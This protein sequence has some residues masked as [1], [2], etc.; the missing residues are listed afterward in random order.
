MSSHEWIKGFVVGYND[1]PNGKRWIVRAKAPLDYC[2]QKFEVALIAAGTK[3]KKGLD[4]TFQ[5]RTI[6]PTHDRHTVATEVTAFNLVFGDTTLELEQT[7]RSF[8]LHPSGTRVVARTL[9]PSKPYGGWPGT[10]IPIRKW[11]ICPLGESIYRNCSPEE[12]IR[13]EQILG[14]WTHARVVKHLTLDDVSTPA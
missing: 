6:G 14:E 5:I 7:E 8:I 9:L 1:T 11:Q 4:V 10:T 12:T 13:L 3:L 2:D